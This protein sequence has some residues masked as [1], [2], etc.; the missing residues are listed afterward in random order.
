MIPSHLDR[1]VLETAIFHARLK[2]HRANRHVEEADRWLAEHVAQEDF[3]K[4]VAKPN[5]YTGDKTYYVVA[6]K[7]FPAHFVLAIGDALHN[8][9]AAADYIASGIIRAVGGDSRKVTFPSHE[10]RDSLRASMKGPRSIHFGKPGSRGA[11][12]NHAVVKAWP[13]FGMLLLTK[14]RPHK[15]GGRLLWEIRQADN[16]DKHELIIPVVAISKLVGALLVDEKSNSK[17][18][19]T[20]EVGPDGRAGIVQTDM[21]FQIKEKGQPA[22]SITFPKDAKVFAGDPVFPTLI[23][24]GQAMFEIIN[25]IEALIHPRPQKAE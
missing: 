9:S 19:T 8:L 16:I 11:G 23:Q 4:I 12:G 3:C 18:R 2:V 25:I 17:I 13:A 6:D 21:D 24:C 20:V 7:P 15:G 10:T 14:I 5:S 22:L 1:A